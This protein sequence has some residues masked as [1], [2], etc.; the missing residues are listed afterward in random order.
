MTQLRPFNYKFALPT[1]WGKADTVHKLMKGVIEVGTPT[2]G[3]ILVGR[4]VARK[5]LSP[6][7]QCI[8][9]SWGQ[10][11]AFEEDC[12]CYAFIYENAA[13]YAEHFTKNNPRTVTE[14]PETTTATYWRKEA[15]ER[16]QRYYSEYF[17]EETI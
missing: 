14:H 13:I 8:G 4:A 1:P 11:L 17:K 16:L 6:Q 3:G 5:L 10:Y 9:F 2:H 12:A 15:K 7:A